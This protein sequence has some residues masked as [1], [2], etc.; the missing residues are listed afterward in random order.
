MKKNKIFISLLVLFTIFIF[1]ID[2]EASEKDFGDCIQS[3]DE[4]ALN[5]P[6]VEDGYPEFKSPSS[7]W[8]PVAEIPN[9]N[10]NLIYEFQLITETNHMKEIWIYSTDKN[11]TFFIYNI[12][13]DSWRYVNSILE[14]SI[15]IKNLILTDEGKIYGLPFKWTSQSKNIPSLTIYDDENK[16]FYLD[17]NSLILPYEDRLFPGYEIDTLD[18]DKILYTEGVF[19]I[20]HQNGDLYSLNVQDQKLIKEFEFEE[21]FRVKSLGILPNGNLLIQKAHYD[22]YL[23]PNDLIEYN[24]ENKSIHYIEPPEGW[25]DYKSY[26]SSNGDLWIGSIGYRDTNNKWI[27]LIDDMESYNYENLNINTV[28]ASPELFFQ[29]SDGITWHRRNTESGY[30]GTAWYNSVTGEGCLIYSYY[31]NIREDSENS[32][33]TIA[34]GMI[35]KLES[36]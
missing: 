20:Y 34:D 15:Q 7:P 13:D 2:I 26:I 18:P 14:D 30:S 23:Q 12:E 21:K 25:R 8:E 5:V 6:L 24:I 32:L 22:Y 36:K 11:R 1:L 9:Y 33:W 16:E 27:S 3:F 28:W 31:G 29:S 4:F 19:W 17:L 10:N 35:Y